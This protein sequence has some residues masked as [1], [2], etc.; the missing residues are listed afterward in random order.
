MIERACLPVDRT[1]KILD[2]YHA[3]EHIADALR[4]CKNL[5][6][7]DRRT[8][9]K[10][11]SRKLLRPGGPLAVIE[12][13]SKLARR[14]RGKRV[15][16]EIKYLR[17]YL[18]HMRNAE[19]RLAK[20]PIGSGIVESAIRRVINLRFKAASMCWREDH[21]AALLYPRC[22]LKSACWEA[23]MHG[24]VQGRYWLASDTTAEPKAV[25]EGA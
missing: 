9:H 21:L 18:D 10:A 13:F 19:W 12:R 6:D 5:S 3:S 11:L 17:K 22:A 14:R 4:A 15:N 8:Q 1:H 25:L 7:N 2:F 24:D 16:K 20:V 23:F